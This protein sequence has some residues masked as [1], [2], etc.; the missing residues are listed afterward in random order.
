MVVVSYEASGETKT[1][2]ACIMMSHNISLHP[3][4]GVNQKKMWN[5]AFWPNLN[6]V[7]TYFV[8]SSVTI[9]HFHDIPPYI[10]TNTKDNADEWNDLSLSLT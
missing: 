2:A 9:S 4:L 10:E 6:H 5:N 7:R 3:S 1:R 8:D